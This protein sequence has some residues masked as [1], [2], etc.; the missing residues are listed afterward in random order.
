MDY[1]PLWEQAWN[2]HVQT[3]KPRFAKD[4]FHSVFLMNQ[5]ST[6][7]KTMEEL[8][9]NPY[10]SN[11]MTACKYFDE[12]HSDKFIPFLS[13]YNDEASFWNELRIH[14]ERNSSAKTIEH[15]L[16]SYPHLVKTSFTALNHVEE[17]DIEYWPCKPLLR[18]SD[19]QDDNSTNNTELYTVIMFQSPT[20]SN[21]KWTADDLYR[22]VTDLPREKITFLPKPYSSDYFVK[23]VFR[24]SIG[25]RDDIF[26]DSWKNLKA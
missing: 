12:A 20:I 15:F 22:I 6:P 5:R 4:A 11:I 2:K 17:K 14:Q 24:H 19:Y 18:Q 8:Q 25:I 1:G 26:P 10:P 23:G 21:T 9:T 3:F 16:E 7:I 13:D